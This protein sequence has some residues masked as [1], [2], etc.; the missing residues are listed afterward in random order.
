MKFCCMFGCF[1]SFF[2]AIRFCVSFTSSNRPHEHFVF[3]ANFTH[4]QISLMNFNISIE[5]SGV[6][7]FLVCIR[8]A[9]SLYRRFYLHVSFLF[10]FSSLL[11]LYNN[12]ALAMAVSAS[13][14]SATTIAID[15]VIV[16]MCVHSLIGL[17]F[18]VA[19]KLV[20]ITL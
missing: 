13:L 5:K 6:F 9:Y 3:I 20:N 19:V 2:L 16:Y 12:D 14:L 11:F 7:S 8:L 1:V 4:M 17:W 15:G 10:V 18:L